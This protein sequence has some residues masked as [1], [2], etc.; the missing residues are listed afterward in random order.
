[1]KEKNISHRFNNYSREKI[2]RFVYYLIL[3]CFFMYYGLVY[4]LTY[5]N[6]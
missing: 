2:G 1:M 3:L 4:K 5:K 6:K